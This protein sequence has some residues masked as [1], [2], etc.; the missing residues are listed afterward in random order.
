MKEKEKAF[1]E[2]LA[3]MQPEEF[4]RLMKGL[5]EHTNR[6]ESITNR[7]EKAMEEAKAEQPTTDPPP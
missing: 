4:D 1:N 2:S 6:M 7:L 3:K 5:E